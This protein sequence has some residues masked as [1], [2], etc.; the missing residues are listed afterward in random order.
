[1]KVLYVINTLYNGGAEAHLL[2]LTQ[3]VQALGGRCEVAFLRASVS[4]GS[5]DLREAFEA[6]GV[7][8][9]YLGCDKA[10]DLRSGAR[11][12]RLLSSGTWDVLHS[13]LPRADAAAAIAKLRDRHQIWIATLHHPYDNAYSGAPLIPLLA[14]MWRLADGVIAVSEPV[15]Q[16]SIERL[17]LRPGNVR[18]V[19]HGIEL[20]TNEPPAP[21]ATRVCIG[22][23]GRYEPRKGHETLIRAMVPILQRFPN[24]QLRI[25]GHDPWGH[26][27]VFRRLITEL[28]LEQHVELTGYMS[29]KQAFFAEIDVFAFASRSEG[30]GIVLIEAM[31]AGKPAVVTD[32]AP[33]NEI[34]EPGRSGLVAAIDDPASFATAL[35]SLFTDRNY[36]ARIGEAGRRR[37]AAEFSRERMIGKTLQFYRDVAEGRRKAS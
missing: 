19:M 17:G 4:G 33:L 22:T 1:M 18:T 32:I 8:T 15:R 14:P 2:L 29:D 12:H 25:A 20:A 5:V 35:L 26:G 37:V 13:H 3:G 21:P 31:A 36:L 27:E 28:R 7:R 24:A 30:F 6:A 34:I 23:I 16:W 10:Y 11:L 9:H